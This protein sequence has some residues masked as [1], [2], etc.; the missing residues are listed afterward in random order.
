M[1]GVTTS[2]VLA[3]LVA[4]SG[5]PDRRTTEGVGYAYPEDPS[6][7]IHEEVALVG[8]HGDGLRLDGRYVR[9]RSTRIEP[10]APLAAVG[11]TPD[12]RYAPGPEGPE[13]CTLSL[14]FCDRFDAVN[15]YWHVDR[16]ARHFWRDRM[17][18]D[19][20]FQADAAVHLA[21]NGALADPGRHLLQFRLGDTYTRNA[22]REDDIVYH[23]YAHLV[24]A[25]LGFVVDT[26][27][28]IPARAVSEGFADYF[29]ATFT[30]DP[31]IGEYWKACTPRYE[32]VGPRDDPDVRTLSTDP[33]TWNWRDGQPQQDLKY[34]VCTRF[35]EMDGK[36]KTIWLNTAAVYVWG[37]IWGSTLW[38]V[39]A[40][41]GADVADRLAADA[42]HRLRPARA[43]LETAAGAVLA[44]DLDR[45]G[46]AHRS[47]LERAFA[48]RGILP[49]RAGSVGVDVGPDPVPVEIHPDPASGFVRVRA[50][51]VR[52]VEV[53]DVLGRARTLDFAA[54]GVFLTVDV[55]SLPV[56]RWWIR[57]SGNGGIPVAPA[58]PIVVVR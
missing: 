43:T 52:R 2:A 38:D 12:F 15:V 17:G 24:A 54:E 36:C 6:H 40:E 34:G 14:E 55:S 23:E 56:G 5:A 35:V 16:V 3:A 48:V 4:F 21:G 50:E 10:G 32:C 26:T 37:M 20:D 42:L 11:S 19:P 18:I 57:L 45:Y 39:R 46:G 28:T 8:L 27:S 44:A 30:D 33:A 41:L 58:R 49:D 22:A 9:V 51:G 1:R 29:A 53:V 47:A 7:G 25:Q 31:G 13:R